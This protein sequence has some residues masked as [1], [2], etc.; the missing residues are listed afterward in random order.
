MYLNG[1]LGFYL[2]VKMLL[3]KVVHC[4]CVMTSSNFIHLKYNTACSIRWMEKGAE[5]YTNITTDTG[6]L[7]HLLEWQN[8]T[9]G[10]KKGNV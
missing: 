5:N 2:G 1:L 7:P 4:N 10:E 9:N 3:N 6:W 8:G